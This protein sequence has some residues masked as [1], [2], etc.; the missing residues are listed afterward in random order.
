MHSI[1]EQ[2]NARIRAAAARLRR[3]CASCDDAVAAVMHADEAVIKI[4]KFNDW[5]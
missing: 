4:S 5:L 1:Y 3:L 2:H